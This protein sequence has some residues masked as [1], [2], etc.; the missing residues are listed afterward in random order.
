MIKDDEVSNN[1]I[2]ILSNGRIF[3]ENILDELDNARIFTSYLVGEI[4]A[5]VLDATKFKDMAVSSRQ[6]LRLY[7]ER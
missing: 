2:T 3:Q 7:D 5:N 4:N 1:A 6:R